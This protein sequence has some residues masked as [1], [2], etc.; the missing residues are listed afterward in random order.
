MV[1]FY[2]ILLLLQNLL[3]AAGAAIAYFFIGY[4]FSFGGDRVIG[5]AE[6]NGGST[7]TTFIGL[8]QFIG[9]GDIDLPFYFY[10]VRVP[11]CLFCLI[12]LL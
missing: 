4:A 11:L 8:S 1:F 3:D 10:Q 5:Q 9:Q 6:P 2:V 7:S 12:I